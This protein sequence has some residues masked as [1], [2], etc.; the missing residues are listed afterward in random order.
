[1][2]RVV[3]LVLLAI[4][5]WVLLEWF[6]RKAI[7]FLGMEPPAGG[8]RRRDGAGP[9]TKGEGES[10]VLV[11]CEACGSY[12]PTSRALPVGR[13]SDRLACSEVCRQRLRTGT[14]R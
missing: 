9:R 8:R 13:G 6:Y 10:E 4:A 12:V 11:R 1:M 14:R 5:F 2:L 7:R 3:V